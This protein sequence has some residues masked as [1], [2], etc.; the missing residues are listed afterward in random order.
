MQIWRR[1]QNFA[2]GQWKCKWEWGGSCAARRRAQRLEVRAATEQIFSQLKSSK[3]GAVERARERVPWRE[4]ERERERD[5]LIHRWTGGWRR[6]WCGGGNGRTDGRTVD[7]NFISARCPSKC[8]RE[9]WQSAAAAET[10]AVSAYWMLLCDNNL[11]KSWREEI[12]E[13]PTGLMNMV[14]SRI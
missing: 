5:F 2:R 13:E 12:S 9:Q 8:E 7:V 10:V 4:R 6:W 14:E 3:D 11:E 1:K